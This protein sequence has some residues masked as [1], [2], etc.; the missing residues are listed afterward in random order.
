MTGEEDRCLAA[1]LL[2][3]GSL[4]GIVLNEENSGDST[5]AGMHYHYTY[6]GHLW[7]HSPYQC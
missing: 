1:G 5:F 4:V 3:L 2:P 7:H 6:R